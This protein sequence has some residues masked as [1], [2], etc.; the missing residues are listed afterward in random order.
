MIKEVNTKPIPSSLMQIN[1][2]GGLNTGLAPSQ[3]QDNEAC[4]M[5]NFYISNGGKLT[6]RLGYKRVVAPIGVGAI[7]SMYVY[8]G[9]LIF[10]HNT[11]LWE[12]KSD[13]STIKLY[14]GVENTKITFFEMN[15][16]LY[17]KDGKKYLQY[18]GKEFI[19][20]LNIAYVPTLFLACNKDG[21]GTEFEQWNLL[22]NKFKQKYSCDGTEK[23]Y[24]LCFD[25][26]TSIDKVILDNKELTL[27]IDY[28]SNLLQGIINFTTTPSKGTDN[29]EIQAT[30]IVEEYYKDRIL[31]AK[32]Y[33]IYGGSNDSKVLLANGSVM[34]RSGVLDPTYFPENFYQVVGNTDEDITGFA[35]QYD[36]CVIF[37]EKS[38]W[39]MRY[40]NG[41][42]PVK[43]LN[44]STGCINSQSIQLIENSPFYLDTRGIYTIIQSNVR[45]ERNVEMVS[46]NVNFANVL[47]QIG[48]MQEQGL[49]EAVTADF[50][51]KYMFCVNNKVYVFDYANKCWYKWTNI[52]ARSFLEWNNKLYWGDSTGAIYTFRDKEDQRAYDDLE[53]PI[54]ALWR[55]KMFDFGADERKKLVERLFFS[56]NASRRTSVKVAY[57]TQENEKINLSET[58]IINDLFDFRTIDF[59]RFAFT[60]TTF[61]RENM[62]K[63][64]AKKIS[65]FQVE[66]LNDLPNDS[67]E[68]ASLDVK[69]RLQG[70]IK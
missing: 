66:I 49:N 1:R 48:L 26:L 30:K 64:K 12:L 19:D 46:E 51:R 69:Y 6:K 17:I 20:V 18:D 65:Y 67:L 11:S 5:E 31:K 9:R 60:A 23:E 33:T 29:L 57:Y 42:Y 56:M 32:L 63:V 53:N 13:Y 38:I 58:P 47:G 59:S 25:K 52:N 10:A 27:N 28:K 3:I 7:N 44:D 50:D 8:N 70:Y 35:K 37:K 62:K 45:D 41:S 55:S 2:F 40:E 54:K 36:Y 43:P 61:P 68:I 24:R 21:A 14:D 22:G 4:I 39:Q 16:K 34:Y 15:D